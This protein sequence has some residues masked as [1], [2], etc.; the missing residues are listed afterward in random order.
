[1]SLT[2]SVG[3]IAYFCHV[4]RKHSNHPMNFNDHVEEKKK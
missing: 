3:G 4:K 2:A 1:M